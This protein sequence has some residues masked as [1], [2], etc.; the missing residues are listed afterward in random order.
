MASRG[1]GRGK[2]IG[3]WGNNNMDNGISVTYQQQ[4]LYPVLLIDTGC[5]RSRFHRGQSR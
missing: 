2:G 1:R 4:P 5:A 3:G